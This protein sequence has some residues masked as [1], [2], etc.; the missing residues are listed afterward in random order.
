MNLR[1]LSAQWAATAYVGVVSLGLNFL[2]A[3]LLGPARFGDYGVAFAAGALLGIFLDGGFRTLLVRERTL[4]S[5]KLA[6][7]VPR[8]HGVAMGHALLVGSV[9]G[10]MAL[11]LGPERR[12]LAIATVASFLGLALTQ[13]VSGALRGEG[14]FAS[15]AAWQ[16]GVRT[17]TAAAILGGLAL[18]VETPTGIFL[19]SAIGSVGVILLFPHG[20][21][22]R[23]RLEWHPEAYRAAVF[24]LWIDLA[25]VVYFRS[26]MLLLNNMGVPTREIGQYVAAYRFIE[27]MILLAMPVGLLV[28]RQLRLEWQDSQNLSRRIW[29]ALFIASLVGFASTGLLIFV[30]EWAVSLAYGAAYREATSL[31]VVLAYSLLFILP[32]T[33]LTQAAIALNHERAYAI[34][35][36]LAALLNVGLNGWLIPRYGV[37]AAAWI[38]VATEGWLFAALMGYLVSRRWA[39]DRPN[40]TNATVP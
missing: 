31:L 24:L 16:A 18:G 3:R 14:R 19:A 11:L 30:A 28:F 33:V 9:M 23:P 20:Q 12:G 15:D 13:F 37:N 26:D 21:T 17:F 35:A 29:R 4:A 40:R 25:T 22:R 39:P 36:T 34:I 32:N 7:L 8:L 6:D 38:T 1:F 2:V 10:L 27:A 5:G